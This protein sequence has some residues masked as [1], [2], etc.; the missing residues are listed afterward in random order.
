MP[1]ANFRY[2]NTEGRWLG[3]T[4]HNVAVD[5]AGG[6]SLV[7]LPLGTTNRRA[8]RALALDGPSGVAVTGGSIWYTD[9]AAGALH[10]SDACDGSA[11]EAPCDPPDLSRPR[12]LAPAREEGFVWLADEKRDRVLLLG[13]DARVVQ[14]VGGSSP[15]PGPLTLPGTLSSPWAVAVDGRGAL[16]V[17]DTGNGR[18][19]KFSPS[20]QVRA[21]FWRQMKQ[22]GLVTRPAAVAIAEGGELRRVFVLDLDRKAI[23]VFDETGAPS[24]PDASEFGQGLLQDPLCLCVSGDL[25]LVG[26]NGARSILAFR[27]GSGRPV[28]IGVVP[29]YAGPVAALAAAPDGTIWVHPGDGPPVSLS[30]LGGYGSRGLMVSPRVSVQDA[31]VVWHRFAATSVALGDHAQ[32]R[33]FIR[34]S[35]DPADMALDLTSPDPFPSP[36]WRPG[37]ANVEA[38]FIDS[39][40]GGRHLWI[41]A[42]LEGD[43]ASSPRIAQIKAEYNHLSYLPLLPAIYREALD[44][45]TNRDDFLLRFL[46]LFETVTDDTASAIEALDTLFA[47]RTAQANALPWLAGLLGIEAGEDWTEDFLRRAIDGASLADAQRGTEAGLRASLADF[48]A[49]SASIDDGGLSGGLWV[50]PGRTEGCDAGSESDWTDGEDARLGFTTFLASAEPYG[51]VL[52]VSATLDAAHL[53]EEQDLFGPVIAATSGQVTIRMPAQALPAGRAEALHRLLTLEIPAHVAVEI[54]TL[55]AGTRLGL[56]VLGQETI[57][58]GPRQPEPAGSGD[59]VLAG[60]PRGQIGQNLQLGRSATL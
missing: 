10:R 30:A 15:E 51:A 54:S 46:S 56:A 48:G 52:D 33:F 13:S 53:I 27:L 17:A 1:R 14:A 26:D 6:A 36:Q 44:R 3:W 23:L 2:L 55:A 21:A 7:P 43:G 25:L 38:G 58:G 34:T 59:L 57:L 22:A 16:Y 28:P 31:K 37:A 9:P 19:Q 32:L 4:L 20:G 39:D 42:I 8:R 5:A 47:D 49:G 24:G 41:G 18:V 50:A 12:G 29:G 11:A 40:A 35:D 60:P 45:E